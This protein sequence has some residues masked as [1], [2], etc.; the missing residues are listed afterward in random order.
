MGGQF[1]TME[2]NAGEQSS[3]LIYQAPVIIELEVS[4]L[5]QSAENIMNETDGGGYYS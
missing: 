3:A 1:L 5:V 2:D 4:Q